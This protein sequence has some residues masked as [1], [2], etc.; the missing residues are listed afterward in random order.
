MMYTY[1]MAFLK[2]IKHDVLYRKDADYVEKFQVV[3]PEL[4]VSR[5]NNCTSY[6]LNPEQSVDCIS[7]LLFC[8]H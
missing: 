1:S 4:T 7:N 5:K 2:Q 8:F 6:L 3:D